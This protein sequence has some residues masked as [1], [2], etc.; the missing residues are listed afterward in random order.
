MDIIPIINKYDINLLLVFGSY[1][2]ERFTKDSDIDLGYL[3]RRNFDSE[4][5]L[6][7]LKDFILLYRR[8]RIDLVNLAT[9]SPLL[10]F[11]TATHGQ[12]LYEENDSF[13]RFKLKA[14]ARYADTGHLRRMRQD[15]LNKELS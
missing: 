4:E 8:D 7:L 2:T 1:Q 6:Q 15:Y 11:E 9:A 13:L 5:E 12:V 3:A 10:M 14:S